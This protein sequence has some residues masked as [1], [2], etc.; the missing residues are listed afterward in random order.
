M[1]DVWDPHALRWWLGSPGDTLKTEALGGG[2]PPIS[3]WCDA[4]D[5]RNLKRLWGDISH[6]NWVL[7]EM[8][9]RYEDGDRSFQLW[10]FSNPTINLTC[11]FSGLRMTQEWGSLNWTPSHLAV[12]GVVLNSFQLGVAVLI[13]GMPR[14]VQERSRIVDLWWS[15]YSLLTLN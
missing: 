10:K 11:W 6:Q 1:F 8:W 14:M 2:E 12:G 15:L 13:H 5:P 3:W 4:W 9:S 7:T